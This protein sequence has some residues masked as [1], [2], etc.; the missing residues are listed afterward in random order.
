MV[1]ALGARPETAD[2]A[3]LRE[4]R[5][6][7]P[8][9]RDND[10]GTWMVYRYDDAARVLTD[11]AAFTSEYAE[12]SALVT[13]LLAGTDT[14]RV[15]V[16]PAMHRE[17]R[18]LVNRR[19]TAGAIAALGSRV[20]TLTNELLDRVAGDARIDLA[21]DL[22]FPLPVRVIAELL[23]VPREDMG[24]VLSWVDVLCG[25]TPP[26]PPL[27]PSPRRVTACDARAE[28]LAYLREHVT[29][30]RR[31][32]DPSAD[33]TGELLH[34]EVDGRLLDD[35]R[36][37]ALLGLLLLSGHL[38]TTSLLA[39]VVLCLDEHPAV[40]DEV[41]AFPEL[42]T[43][44][45][46]EVLRYRT[47]VGRVTRRA[48]LDVELGGQRILAGDQVTVVMDSVNQDE[49]RFTAPERFDIHRR[50]TSRLSTGYGLPFGPGSPVARLQTRM[51]LEL[52][53]WRYCEISVERAELR[54]H[55]IGWITVPTSMPLR[56]RSASAVHNAEVPPLD[57]KGPHLSRGRRH[58][59]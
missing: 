28:L 20:L 52:L 4:M 17:L 12:A 7:E 58:S 33:M 31:A 36:V 2:R 48:K 54:T 18:R 44:V 49:R 51:A 15:A 53:L 40:S 30:A 25:T 45:I 32:A 37:V 42:L 29:R 16:D 22:A 6:C 14:E 10:S 5:G 57:A 9:S 38:T 19:F 43:P 55:R 8:V 46:E 59:R 24:S 39:S 13:R 11:H 1:E 26:G 34:A 35:D 21:T 50:T 56:V 3:R 27:V 23:G 41:R 47:P